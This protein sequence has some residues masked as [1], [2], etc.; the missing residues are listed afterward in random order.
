MSAMADDVPMES[1]VPLAYP[2]RCLTLPAFELVG[3]TQIVQSGGAL[4]E[5]VRRDG[6]WEELRCLA[7]EGGSIYGVASH[8]SECPAGWYR[9]TMAAARD[10]QGGEDSGACH[11]IH[12]PASEWVA[13]TL[14]DFGALYG[15]F[16]QADPYRLIRQLGWEFNAAVG[17][18]LDVFGPAFRSDHDAMEFLM[19]VRRP[20]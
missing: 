13:F 19:P 14:E 15:E 8:D 9:Y 12:V 20:A 5:A 2:A 6:R 16:W 7:G 10:A 1:P 18:H 3:Y 17:M 11:P 4:Y